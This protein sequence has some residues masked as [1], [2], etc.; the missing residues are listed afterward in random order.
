MKIL[1]ACANG[2]GTTLMMKM[3][4]E[5]AF[6]E[7]GIRHD[8]ITPAGLEEGKKIAH[9]FDA[10]FC[11]QNLCSHFDNLRA[12]GTR[13]VAMRYIMDFEEAKD[14]IRRYQWV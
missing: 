9:E 4:I 6:K 5:R 7:L 10:V 3:N 8:G 1:V 12:K 11:A 2:V 14:Q 13:I